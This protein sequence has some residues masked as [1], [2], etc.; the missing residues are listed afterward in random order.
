M[1]RFKIKGFYMAK[2]YITQERLKKNTLSDIFML[3]LE[4]K[5][6]TRREIEYETGFSWG[7]VSGNVAL[8]IEKGYV[9]EEKSEQSGG[10]GRTTYLLKPTSDNVASLGL[11][12]NRA[13]LCCEIVALDS[14]VLKNFESEFTAL[15]QTE[16]LEQ[17]ESLCQAAID[18]CAEN[19]LRIFSLGIAIQGTVNGRSGISIHFP[20]IEDWQP[21]SIKEHFAKKFSLPVY[22]GHDPK[23]MLLGEMYRKKYDDC[24][25]IRIDRGIGMAISLDGKILDDTGRF[26]LGHTLAVLDGRRCSCGKKGCLE[27]YGTLSAIS[28]AQNNIESL[29]KSPEK[30]KT[31][32]AEAGSYF[33]K[34]LYNI[35]T[36]LKP[37]RLILTG[38]A[39]VLDSFTEN[40]LS[41]LREENVDIVVDS[42]ISAAYGVAVESAKSAIRS[43]NI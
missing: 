39:T 6:T 38:K 8:L 23:C 29:L 31:E 36:L 42:K 1:D 2:K 30:F 25:L 19:G 40:A 4:K 3:I 20:G 26:E 43:F 13:G 33:S 18:W 11:D 10:A 28:T 21:Y 32:L 5:Q 41:L 37:Q 9:K 22:L 12:I 24:V 27:V 7:T 16:L 14:R 15:T 34:A 35:Y 17:S